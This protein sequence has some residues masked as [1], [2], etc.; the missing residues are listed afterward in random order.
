MAA[1]LGDQQAALKPCEAEPLLQ[2][3]DCLNQDGSFYLYAFP[4]LS[5][6]FCLYASSPLSGHFCLYAFPPL[7]LWDAFLQN[8]QLQE[9]K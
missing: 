3:Y 5:G 8:L 9:L 4:P 7:S 6:S 1:Q 2:P